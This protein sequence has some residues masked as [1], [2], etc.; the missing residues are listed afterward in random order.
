MHYTVLIISLSLINYVFSHGVEHDTIRVLNTTNS[1]NSTLNGTRL[2]QTN[3]SSKTEEN[4]TANAEASYY[5]NDLFSRIQIR[6]GGFI[7]Y[8]IGRLLAIQLNLKNFNRHHVLFLGNI[9]SYLELYKSFNRCHQTKGSCKQY[10]YNSFS[11][12]AFF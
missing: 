9:I 1:T 10:F 8:L 11:F 5:P 7:L 3:S 4:K 6:H 12:K 2:N